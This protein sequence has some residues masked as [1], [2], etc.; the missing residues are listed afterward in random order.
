MATR[1]F[2]VSILFHVDL[3]DK[4]RVEFFRSLLWDLTKASSKGFGN[5]K[6]KCEETQASIN[7]SYPTIPHASIAELQVLPEHKYSKTLLPHE[8]RMLTP[9]Q[10]LGDGNCLYRFVTNLNKHNYACLNLLD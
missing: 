4:A 3:Q 8:Q 6:M 10:C 5:L 2:L 7:T 1:C 9:L